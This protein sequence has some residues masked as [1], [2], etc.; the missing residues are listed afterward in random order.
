LS[1]H[2]IVPAGFGAIRLAAL[3]ARR[4]SFP[5]AAAATGCSSGTWPW[6][7]QTSMIAI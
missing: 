7:W 1:A 3:A 5:A 4:C 6:Q 2:L